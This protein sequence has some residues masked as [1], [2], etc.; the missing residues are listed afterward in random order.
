MQPQYDIC[1]SDEFIADVS[2]IFG[3]IRRWD[4]AFMGFEGEG[5]FDWYLARLPRGD[6]TWSLSATGDYRLAV[7]EGGK[8]QD[9]SEFPSVHFT[10]RLLLDPSPHLLLQRA[11]RGNDPALS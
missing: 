11:R 10:Y 3:D 1:W 2:E 6:N 5:G 4:E 8:L 7:L 9:G